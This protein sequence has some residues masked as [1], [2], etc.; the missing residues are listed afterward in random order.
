MKWLKLSDNE[1]IDLEKVSY[2]DSAVGTVFV[3]GCVANVT[4]W[5]AKKVWAALQEPNT[6]CGQ[7]H[8]AQLMDITPRER[9]CN[10]CGKRLNATD[11]Y[12]EMVHGVYHADCVPKADWQCNCGKKHFDI[13]VSKPFSCT[14]GLPFGT[15]RK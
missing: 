8:A 6:M 4:H 10:G 1:M 12:Y 3:D 15:P 7:Y 14:C 9:L 11:V 13:N 2:V 5:G